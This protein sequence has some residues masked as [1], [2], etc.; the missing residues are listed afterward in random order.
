VHRQ[1][2]AL[3]VEPQLPRWWDYGVI[4]LTIAA[5]VLLALDLNVEDHSRAGLLVGW[6][7]A[8]FCLA[9]AADFVGRLLKAE[10]RWTF[11]RRNW[12]D[13]VGAIPIAE[14]LRLARLVRLVRLLRLLRMASLGRRLLVRYDVEIPSSLRYLGAV[15]LVVWIG[16]GL[17]FYGFESGHNQGVRSIEDAL[18]WSM[19]T[20]STVGYGDLYPRSTGGR[21]VALVTMVL[22]VGVL[23]TLAASLAA[24]FV[25]ARNR[26]HRGL[27]SLVM[28]DHLMVLGWN[29]KG[30]LTLEEF[31]G[32][33]RFQ[34]IAVVVV[35]EREETPIDE[36][37]IHFV[38]GQPTRIEPLERAS[39]GSAV[40]AIVLANDPHDARSDHE[41]ALVV[42]QLRRLN[43]RIRISAE[44]VDPG[45]AE[46]VRQ[47]GS[48]AIVSTKLITSA[49]LARSVQD[50][51]ALELVTDLLSSGEGS[52]IYRVPVPPQYAGKPFR[53]YA[54]HM[55]E[56]ACAVVAISRSGGILVNPEPG[57][58]LS[59]GDEAFVVAADPPG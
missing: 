12:Y 45:N 10:Q 48:D 29:D 7:D 57:Y 24:A 47:A 22:G 31:R 42:H 37:R 30:M 38:R 55:L 32:D 14:P 3:Y 27:R 21:A 44:L 8:G 28:K 5:L 51:G 43:P 58:A 59:A 26:G 4:G 49:L 56:R 34:D 41:T 13:L 25:E 23:G 40:A 1:R 20:L 6:I 46:L 18:W 36:G 33:P 50:A 39:A 54:I 19:S 16:T 52:E 15:S 53:D 2:R 11:V 17:A 9:F 35:A